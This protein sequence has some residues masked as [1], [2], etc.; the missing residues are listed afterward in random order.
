MHAIEEANL[1]AL[2]A[3]LKVLFQ[4][5]VEHPVLIDTAGGLDQG[6]VAAGGAK[7]LRHVHCCPEETKRK[8]K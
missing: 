2:Q 3:I 1:G 6:I 8:N 4:V 5:V 7:L